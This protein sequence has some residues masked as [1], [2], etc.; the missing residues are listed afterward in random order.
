MGRNVLQGLDQFLSS[1]HLFS[2]QYVEPE[3]LEVCFWVIYH[4]HPGLP[5]CLITS[6]SSKRQAASGP[7]ARGAL[8]VCI[9]A[10]TTHIFP[11]SLSD[12]LAHNVSSVQERKTTV[13]KLQ[14]DQE[15]IL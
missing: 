10:S 1:C 8:C 14:R 5:V 13:E 3:P 7:A 6:S 12:R 2:T 11:Y 9:G 4:R 15:N